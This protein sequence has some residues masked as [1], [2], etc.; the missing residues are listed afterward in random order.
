MGDQK[1]YDTVIEQIKNKPVDEWLSRF[2]S[3]V[4]D[5]NPDIVDAFRQD[6]DRLYRIMFDACLNETLRKIYLDSF[7]SEPEKRDNAWLLKALN[8]KVFNAVGSYVE[9]IESVKQ[10]QAYTKAIVAMLGGARVDGYR[11]AFDGLYGKIYGILIAAFQMSL[12]EQ[13]ALNAYVKLT[14]NDVSG[15]A[16]GK[17]IANDKQFEVIFEKWF[18]ISVKVVIVKEP[19]KEKSENL[20]I[21]DIVTDQIKTRPIEEWKISFVNLLT[22]L[23][24]GK[25]F[26]DGFLKDY[27]YRHQIKRVNLFE[28]PSVD[29][30][31]RVKQD[32]SSLISTFTVEIRK[33]LTGQYKELKKRKHDEIDI[34]TEIEN[35]RI[36]LKISE[37]IEKTDIYYPFISRLANKV[38]NFSI[39]SILISDNII[40]DSKDVPKYY[41]YVQD[42]FEQK[43]SDRFKMVYGQFRY[44]IRDFVKYFSNLDWSIERPKLIEGF[45]KKAQKESEEEAENDMDASVTLDMEELARLRVENVRL[46]KEKSAYQT[47]AEQRQLEILKLQKLPSVTDCMS[48]LAQCKETLDK[49]DVIIKDNANNYQLFIKE[50]NKNVKLMEDNEKLM[51]Q[52]AIISSENTK[53]KKEL[54]EKKISIEKQ[55]E[56]LVNSKLENNVLKNQNEDLEEN[57]RVAEEKTKNFGACETENDKL[58]KENINLNNMMNRCQN[59]KKI[60]ESELEENER[61][62]REIQAINSKLEEQFSGLEVNLKTEA[63]EN[64]KNRKKVESLIDL[65]KNSEENFVN[66]E[67]RH[68]LTLAKVVELRK[69][70][71]ELQ[72]NN[73]KLLSDEEIY[74][75]IMPEIESSDDESSS[76]EEQPDF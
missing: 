67:Q 69:K 47:L 13:L 8:P 7:A 2:T 45:K 27:D 52:N 60:L 16:R 34:P 57:I 31:E 72:E 55:R 3:I 1:L 32:Q 25:D 56:E 71:E 10:W 29:F 43:L 70:N 40:V 35:D 38:N 49:Q 61:I 19:E 62:R 50:Q 54:D 24:L 12:R 74:L 4:S 21:Y 75:S 37:E 28:K 20:H 26:V 41:G 14:R 76:F 30:N 46:R 68:N 18:P 44:S 73:R 64:T 66:L 15:A 6:H 59:E 51:G 48:E 42:Y 58:K 5:F 65:L 9:K 17:I 22:Q 39:D 36:L 23:G 11:E 53:L 63:E 33:Q